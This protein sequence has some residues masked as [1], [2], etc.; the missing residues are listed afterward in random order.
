MNRECKHCGYVKP[1]LR[2]RLRDW[3]QERKRRLDYEAA[4]R[5]MTDE[6][7]RQYNFSQSMKAIRKVSEAWSGVKDSV[8]DSVKAFA[9]KEAEEKAFREREASRCDRCG[10]AEWPP[11]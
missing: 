1:T 5:G 9:T 2:K 3:L 7:R 8:L 6:E 10:T 11:Y 4:T